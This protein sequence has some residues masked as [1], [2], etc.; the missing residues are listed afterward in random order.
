MKVLVDENNNHKEYLTVLNNATKMI[1]GMGHGSQNRASAGSDSELLNRRDSNE[2]Q[3]SPVEGDNAL[4]PSSIQLEIPGQGARMGISYIAGTIAP[5]ELRAF[6]KM[7][8]RASKG[9]VMSFM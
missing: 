3:F 9:K 8:F 2:A 7:I 4:M 5:K 6:Q 1:H